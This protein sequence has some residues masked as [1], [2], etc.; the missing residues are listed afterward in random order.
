MV[1]PF[2]GYP[3]HWIPNEL[4]T[5]HLLLHLLVPLFKLVTI[6]WLPLIGDHLPFI[7]YHLPF[8]GYDLP[9]IGYH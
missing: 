7:G 6:D 9:F 2:I 3:I 5:F 4:A 8:I 1:T